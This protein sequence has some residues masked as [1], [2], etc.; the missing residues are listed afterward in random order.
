MALA[1]GSPWRLKSQEAHEQGGPAQSSGGLWGV[2][3][4]PLAP[5]TRSK[6]TKA[7]PNTR[8]PFSLLELNLTV[9]TL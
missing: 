4:E 9:V 3:D 5:G 6:D 8:A 7:S 2:E 1:R